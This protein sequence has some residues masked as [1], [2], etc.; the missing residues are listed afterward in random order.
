MDKVESK[1]IL[2]RTSSKFDAKALIKDMMRE[3]DISI[4]GPNPWDIRIHNENFYSRL[5]H[6]GGIAFGE[7][8]MD[9]WWDCERIDMLIDRIF[10]AR[11][12]A[13]LDI[14]LN[15]KLHILMRRFINYQTK[16]LAKKV[17]HV[18]Y[19]LGNTLFERMLDKQMIYSC[20]YF[21]EAKTL[22]E[23]QTA[24][25]DLICRKLYL[26]PGEHLLDIGCGWGGLA[27]YAATHYGVK[28]TGLTIS[29]Q[30]ALFARNYCKDLPIDIRLQDYRDIKEKYDKIVSV[31][32]F[33]H[34]GHLNYRSFM[35]IVY[36]AL[37][38]DGLFLLHTIGGN[39][40]LSLSNP[41]IAKY[42]FPNGSIPSVKQVGESF[43]NIFI[44]EDW[45]N[46][47]PYYDK[48]LM[49]WYQNF[50]AHWHEI[51][52]DYDERFYRM[53]V[54]YLLSCAGSFRSRGNQLWQIILS[55]NNTRLYQ[56]IR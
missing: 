6:E 7:A 29:E 36:K 8:Y 11:L 40:T 45:H 43:E 24:K 46:F 47:G 39:S 3:T 54:F 22:D 31:G 51:K 41:W 38:D 10:R 4:N 18:H 14:P 30:Q 52:A 21:K 28:V 55:K 27:K 12:D 34:V 32:M 25:L 33:E 49:A 53:W 16:K 13:K 19:N 44:M 26:K 37:K 2:K 35:E 17:A 42:I 9:K 48:T 5:I 1:S 23:A 56:S 50:T 15:A 20:A